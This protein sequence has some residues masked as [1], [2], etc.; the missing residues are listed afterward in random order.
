MRV[1]FAALFVYAGISLAIVLLS[2]IISPGPLLGLIIGFV[3]VLLCLLAMLLFNDP[4]IPWKPTMDHEQYIRELEGRGL[5]SDTD[6]RAVRAFAVEEWD[7]E[8]PHYFLELEDG[9]I[10][11]L[12]GQYLLDYEPI[13]DDAEWNQERRFP[14]TDFT[15]RRHL[16]GSFVVEIVCRG[17]ALEPE[18]TAPPFNR[19]YYRRGSV[20][21]DGQILSEETY[22]ELRERR[23]RTR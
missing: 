16:H 15:V 5:L 9:S 23:V 17:T 8:G 20:P 21:E 14:C 6:F 22:E 1:L 18:L 11:Y 19:E 10:L 4:G 12:N 13:D 3:A 7:D 2:S